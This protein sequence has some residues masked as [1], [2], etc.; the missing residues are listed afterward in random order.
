M[1]F[2]INKLWL[3]LGSVRAKSTLVHPSVESSCAQFLTC[4]RPPPNLV[5]GL[6][7]W[8]FVAVRFLQSPIAAILPHDSAEALFSGFRGISRAHFANARPSPVLL[9]PSRFLGSLVPE[10]Q[11]APAV[12]RSPPDF[13]I[14]ISKSPVIVPVFRVLKSQ[15]S[16]PPAVARPER[17]LCPLPCADRS[18]EG[19][20]F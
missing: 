6:L 18:P 5:E 4:N 3:N 19:G 1:S 12:D 15:I 9:I 20:Y 8:Q 17:N 16:N 2:V 11:P 13:W 10:A 14:P 7:G